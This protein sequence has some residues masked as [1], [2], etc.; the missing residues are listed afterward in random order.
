MIAFTHPILIAECLEQHRDD[1]EG[2]LRQSLRF[3]L[4]AITRRS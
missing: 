2:A 3:L 4:R 1:L